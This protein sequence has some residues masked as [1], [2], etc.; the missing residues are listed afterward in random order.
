M[1]RFVSKDLWPLMKKLSRGNAKH[2]AIAY[3]ASDSHLAFGDGDVLVTD[4]SNAL[5]EGGQTSARVL[6]TAH[7]KG[8]KLYSLR[9]SPR[10][11]GGKPKITDHKSRMWLAGVDELAPEAYESD[12]AYIEQGEELAEAERSEDDSDLSWIRYAGNS[13]FRRDAVPGDCVIQIW[14]ELG[15]KKVFVYEPA[16]VIIRRSTKRHAYFHI[17]ELRGS[18]RRAI[19]WRDFVKHWRR[20]VGTPPPSVNGA[21]LLRDDL[22]DVLGSLWK[23]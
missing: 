18:E 6:Q 4:A 15:S 3:V 10:A 8:A 16:A 7:A 19:P 1:N 14:Q 2:A 17:E 12:A 22:A 20:L 13:K 11:P 5:I 23:S 9:G 21:R